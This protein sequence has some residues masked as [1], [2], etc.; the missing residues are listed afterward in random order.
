MDPLRSFFVQPNDPRH[1]QYEVLRAVFVEQQSMAAAA[2]RFGYRADTVRALA[3]QFRQQL[4][5]GQPPPFLLNRN[6]DGLPARPTPR[7]RRG[8]TGPLRP[9]S[10]C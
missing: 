1:R 3:S 8:R 6:A 10:V 9:M 5:V 2:Q 4:A 7:R